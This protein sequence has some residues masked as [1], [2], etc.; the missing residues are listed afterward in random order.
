MNAWR[1]PVPALLLV[2]AAALSGC[3]RGELSGPPEL[4][5]GRDECVECG[6]LVSED[7]S[8]ASMLIEQYGR[9]EYVMFDDIGCLLDYQRNRGTEFTEVE[10]FV[11]D[12]PTGAWV[13]WQDALFLLAD[14]HKLVTPM[15]SGL[16]AFASRDVALEWQARY[17]GELLRPGE[18][19]EAR[20][21]WFEEMFG[22]PSR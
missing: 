5:L 13:A 7:R 9:R 10:S 1:T 16:A 19:G 18:I 2:A 14:R 3:S 20:R 6:M 4:R 22:S 8:S 17:G 15:G 21:V 12:H 11:H